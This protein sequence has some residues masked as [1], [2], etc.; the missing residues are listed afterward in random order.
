MCRRTRRSRHGRELRPYESL[1]DLC[2]APLV[3][4]HAGGGAG[5][6]VRD[7]RGEGAGGAWASWGGGCGMA[8]VEVVR[9][10][11]VDVACCEDGFWGWD[12]AWTC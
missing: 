7:A 10:F 5:V 8:L 3:T 1:R 11:A 12:A 4:A 9:P 6:G 2:C